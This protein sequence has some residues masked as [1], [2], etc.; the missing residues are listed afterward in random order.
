MSRR[1]VQ[2][3][4]ARTAESLFADKGF[5]ETTVDEIA[6]AVGMSQRS[7]FRYFSSKDD[8]VFDSVER[9]RVTLAERL[10]SRPIDECAWE[11]LRRTFDPVA[12]RFAD[13]AHRAHDKAVQQIIDRSPRLLAA[14]LCHLERLQ[15][16]LTEAILER[17]TRR[18]GRE[19]D[20]VVVRAMVG[21]ACACLHAAT[22]HA[23]G[24]PEVFDVSLDR[25]M[26]ALRPASMPT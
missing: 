19:P 10:A 25:A 3:R 23:T 24:D 13:P 2:S 16:T 15:R 26:S 14:Y 17:A 6:A 4:I 22:L 7:F 20:P 21:G 5:E 18:T 12:E 1:A 11:S 9:L 8:V